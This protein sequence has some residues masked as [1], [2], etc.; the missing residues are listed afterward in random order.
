VCLCEVWCVCLG[1]RSG[2]EVGVEVWRGE[3]WCVC[4]GWRCGVEVGLDVG[5]EC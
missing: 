3:V 5:V 4:L 1:L 2:V